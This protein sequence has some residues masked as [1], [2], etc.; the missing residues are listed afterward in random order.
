MLRLFHSFRSSRRTS[1]PS[2]SC[3]RAVCIRLHAGAVVF[4][5]AS[6][7]LGIVLRMAGS[8]L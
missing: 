8:H 6:V 7:G 1:G 3:L 5:A 4:A 2:V